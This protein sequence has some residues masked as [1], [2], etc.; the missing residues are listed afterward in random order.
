[1]HRLL[2]LLHAHA[3]ERIEVEPSSSPAATLASEVLVVWWGDDDSVKITR[4][5]SLADEL[6][7]IKRRL[8]FAHLKRR[9]KFPGTTPSFL[10]WVHFPLLFNNSSLEARRPTS[11]WRRDAV[12]NSVMHHIERGILRRFQDFPFFLI[13]SY[14]PVERR[15]IEASGL[16]LIS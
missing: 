4:L 2:L 3:R 7:T 6:R 10:V 15:N 11:F 14:F 12:V 5:S 16:A 1:M 8:A 13:S 9:G